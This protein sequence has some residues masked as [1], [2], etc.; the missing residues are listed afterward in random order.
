MHKASFL[1]SQETEEHPSLP[2]CVS[3]ERGKGSRE[4]CM[5]I[6]K[7]I[8]WLVEWLEIISH[9]M[10]YLSTSPHCNRQKV[11]N[12][13]LQK[14]TS[15]TGRGLLSIFLNS[16]QLCKHLKTLFNNEDKIVFF[17]SCINSVRQCKTSPKTQWIQVPAFTN[18]TKKKNK[19]KKPKTCQHEGCQA[20]CAKAR[21]YRNET[22]WKG[23]CDRWE[24]KQLLSKEQSAQRSVRW[25]HLILPLTQALSSSLTLTLLV[26]IS[27]SKK[28]L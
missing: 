12:T 5:H 7:A 23:W 3:Q 13:S 9:G 27:Q 4:L 14:I 15:E 8:F 2:L 24:H 19:T 21:K 6:N 26:M 25:Q 17:F 28:F 11:S 10:F 16:E 18:I 22:L 1:I 20:K